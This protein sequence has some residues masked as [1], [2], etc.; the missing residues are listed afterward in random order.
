[1]TAS[2]SAPIPPAML[3]AAT[4]GD[5]PE[6]GSDAY[7][8]AVHMMNPRVQHDPAGVILAAI[9]AHVSGA[10]RFAAQQGLRIAVRST[11]HGLWP[12]GRDTLI[13]DVSAMNTIH[14]DPGHGTA[15]VGPGAVWKDVL[16][17]AASRGFGGLA[18]SSPTVGTVGFH[19]GG[20]IGPVSRR[21]GFS[22]DHVLS[23]DVVTADGIHTTVSPH[24]ERELFWALR[25]GGALAIVTAMTFALVP[26]TRL[27][28]GGLYFDEKDAAA[29]LHR[30]HD[31]THDLPEAF[32]TSA[33]VIDIPGHPRVPEPIRGRRVLHVRY[34][35]VDVEPAVVPP[36]TSFATPLWGSIGPMRYDA[37]GEI[38]AEPTRAKPTIQ[39]SMLLKELSSSAIDTFLDVSMDDGSALTVRELRLMGGAMTTPQREPNAVAG[40]GA[41]FLLLAVG[42]APDTRVQHVGRSLRTVMAG[43]EPWSTGGVLGVFAGDARASER[44]TAAWSIAEQTRLRRIRAAADPSGM[45]DPNLRWAST[46]DAEMR[47]AK[48]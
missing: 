21:Y 40:R 37:L 2:H 11:G 42:D 24:Q 28:G 5:A 33:A 16:A 39:D 25:G 44:I 17:A 35:D 20:G 46:P 32:S 19:L 14:I 13:V 30:W 3:I 10:V 22:A 12:V 4:G 26:G 23:F 29:V 18:G 7:A 45:F 8:A 9:P 47:T 38:H 1:M 48:V 43:M 34:A 41:A 15:T 6:R 31:W 36:V 27:R